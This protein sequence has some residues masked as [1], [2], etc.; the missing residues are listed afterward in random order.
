MP[1]PRMP[2]HNTLGPIGLDLGARTPHAMQVKL[3]V[4]APRTHCAARVH[5]DT[6]LLGRM[7]AAVHAMKNAGFVG[8]E[9]VVGLPA[10]DARM[11]VARFPALE[12]ADH[13]EAVSWEAAERTACAR[14]TIVADSI[15]TEAPSTSGDSKNEF[16]V[17]SA[18]AT[19]LTAA[20]DL[21]IDNGFDPIA[22]E[23]RFAAIARALG[24]RVRRDADSGTIRAVLHVEHEGATV[25]V[26]RGDRVAFCRE[27]A[28]GGD[29]L[30]HAVA[31]RLSIAP[32][33]ATVLRA[34][35][36]AAS[37][38]C[39]PPIDPAAEE[40]ALAA[41]RPTLDA[42]ANELALCLRYF[43][44]TFRGGQPT[45]VILSG[46]HGGEPR[47]AE[48]IEE[49]CRASVSSFDA[50]LPS[51]AALLAGDHSDPPAAF[52][53]AYG[54]SCRGRVSQRKEVAA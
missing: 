31:A 46:P 38:G 13:S 40:A 45:R 2:W 12:G 29:T 8:R 52:L 44:V 26:L 54:L 42:L 21:L 7:H 33:S 14:D 53:A 3:G 35:R 4:D 43:G 51:A 50:E 18:N 19:E 28:L 25:L 49:T 27:I 36:I 41:T 37:R 34:R 39:A 47:F 10:H 22:V 9:V 30:D 6:T 15:A 23:P 24:R 32:E 17:V 48:I 11:H 20:L 16:L 5:A 1:F